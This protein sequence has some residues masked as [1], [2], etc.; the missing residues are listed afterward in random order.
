VSNHAEK[1]ANRK[2]GKKATVKKGKLSKKKLLGITTKTYLG[3]PWRHG[4]TK[5]EMKDHGPG[6]M[7]EKK[8]GGGPRKS[9]GKPLK[10]ASPEKKMKKTA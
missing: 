1:V 9:P 2:A 4:P 10:G 5:R 8:K 7:L 6:L 3:R